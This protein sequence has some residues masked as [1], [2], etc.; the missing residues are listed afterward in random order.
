MNYIG[1]DP[2]KLVSLASELNTLLADYHIYYQNLRR[3]HWNVSGSSFFDLHS[4]FET[5]YD[6]AKVRI[7]DIAERLLTLGFKPEGQLSTYIDMAMIQEPAKDLS[8][9]DMITKLL[10]DHRVLIIRKRQILQMAAAC[11]DEGTIDLIAGFLRE[12]EKQSWKLDAWQKDRAVN[13]LNYK[14]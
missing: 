8:N 11:N 1:L 3:F 14:N 9:D 4:L 6:Q 13:Y 5:F 10:D 2:K 12:L 7:D